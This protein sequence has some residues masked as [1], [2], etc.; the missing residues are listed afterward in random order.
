MYEGDS[1][2]IPQKIIPDE[3]EN[4][5][6]E[7]AKKEPVE[8]AKKAVE[9]TPNEADKNS[10]ATDCCCMVAP[11][12]LKE[13]GRAYVLN[14]TKVGQTKAM[15]S[16]KMIDVSVKENY[17]NTE[18]KK[19]DFHIVTKEP[20][21]DGK[22]DY[23]EITS[24]HTFLRKTC[25]LMMLLKEE[26]NDVPSEIMKKYLKENENFKV[27][28]N[29]DIKGE[30]KTEK[31]KAQLNEYQND[32]YFPN[33]CIGIKD[34]YSELNNLDENIND[35]E[36]KGTLQEFLNGKV[37]SSE[38]LAQARYFAKC[39]I[40][41]N[42]LKRQALLEEGYIR[43]FNKGWEE[44][45]ESEFGL[46]TLFSTLFKPTAPKTYSLAPVGSPTKCPTQPTVYLQ[47]HPYFKMKGLAS[48]SVGEHYV[49]RTLQNKKSEIT[50]T[51]IK[52]AIVLEIERGSKKYAFTHE[53]NKEKAALKLK[54]KNVQN[55]GIVFGP[56]SK[57]VSKIYKVSAA[58]NKMSKHRGG[59]GS[60]GFDPGMTKFEFGAEDLML[61]EDAASHE[62]YWKGK[63]VLS[64][65]FFDGANI[66]LDL[67]PYVIGL[68]G[69]I[70]KLLEKAIRSSA[71]ELSK[72][73][74]GG[75]ISKHINGSIKLE[76][77]I[78]GSAK[79]AL[80]LD[81]VDK[82]TIASTGSITGKIEFSI[83]GLAEAGL[84][85]YGVEVGA[86]VGFKSGSAKTSDDG[87]DI[88]C[89]LEIKQ[90]KQGAMPSFGGD[91]STDG[92]AIYYSWY[93]Y[94]KHEDKDA[95]AEG[96]GKDAWS[97]KPELK[98]TKDDKIELIKPYSIID[99]IKKQLGD[100]KDDKK[101]S[102]TTSA[103]A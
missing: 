101:N 45:K 29:G 103:T 13:E 91:I 28:T 95:T 77:E 50:N 42:K 20:K 24:Q 99:E 87:T 94:W 39:R 3:T 6:P 52:A 60:N 100:K 12:R 38:E 41:V 35:W 49:K 63:A 96:G 70:A 47:V 68:G 40:V 102:T 81:F 98:F 75:D 53:A 2:N 34:P 90:A 93:A 58:A 37:A 55:S 85:A 82:T 4:Q 19:F 66:T 59:K 61:T 31:V 26:D 48:F 97:H 5:E 78:K 51:S 64:L 36:I 67:I 11:W 17:S 80:E 27:D 62:V 30:R 33:A 71:E 92:L 79:G 7:V 74:V 76:V 86:G 84:N 65:T 72:T 10:D 25:D 73:K 44:N 32:V 83:I 21:A 15:G 43:T 56:F 46:V 14:V 23:K 57:M 22:V 54:T 89:K 88:S 16:E 18:E 1:I 8:E 69:P 9:E